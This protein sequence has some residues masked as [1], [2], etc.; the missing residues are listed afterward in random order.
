M[1]DCERGRAGSGTQNRGK[2]RDS[3]PRLDDD[4]HV[5][6]GIRLRAGQEHPADAAPLGLR[7]GDRASRIVIQPSGKHLL[8]THPIQEKN[9]VQGCPSYDPSPMPTFRLS[10]PRAENRRDILFNYG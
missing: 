3:L 6:G 4:D 1:K 2:L 9:V 10:E 7:P 5:A 8:P